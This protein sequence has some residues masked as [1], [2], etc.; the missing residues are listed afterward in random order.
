MAALTEDDARAALAAHPLPANP[1]VTVGA[2]AILI[3][4]GYT[5]TL[6]RLLRWV[7]KAR[8]RADLRCWSVPL[9]GAELVRSVLPE[10]SRLAE[11]MQEA[12]S[13][14]SADQPG[15]QE[16]P[17]DAQALALFLP[18]RPGHEGIHLAEAIALILRRRPRPLLFALSRKAGMRLNQ[19]QLDEALKVKPQELAALETELDA[20]CA[21]LTE[22]LFKTEFQRTLID[23]RTGTPY[24]RIAASLG[25]PLL[26]SLVA[27]Q[28]RTMVNHRS[29]QGAKSSNK[30]GFWARLF[31]RA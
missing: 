23:A 21:R 10:I 7:P 2:D 15:P 9:A 11:A 28:L 29:R 31:R 12:P 19:Q 4:A 1:W 27:G 25:D 14:P 24:E 16:S 3:R 30:A 17:A 8:W 20:R 18:I 13:A 5:D 22:E 26:E 6:E